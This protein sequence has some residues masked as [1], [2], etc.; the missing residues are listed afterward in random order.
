MSSWQPIATAPLGPAPVLLFL[1]KPLSGN[2]V[3][4]WASFDSLQVVIGWRSDPGFGGSGWDS[5]FLEDGCADTEGH[6][7]PT[8][9]EVRPSHWMPL[10]AAPAEGAAA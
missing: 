7:T 1:P 10:P 4:G 6:S 2:D 9:V 5:C 8:A 3:V